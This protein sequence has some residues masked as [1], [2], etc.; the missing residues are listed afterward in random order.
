MAK[1]Q[2]DISAQQETYR[3]FNRIMTIST[4]SVI[5]LLALMAAFLT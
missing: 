2:M 1:G 4:V 5:V 3:G